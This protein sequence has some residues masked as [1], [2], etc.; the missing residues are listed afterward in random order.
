MLT[1]LETAQ[2]HINNRRYFLVHNGERVDI[3]TRRIKGFREYV[4]HIAKSTELKEGLGYFF[5]NEYNF[6]SFGLSE[7]V[8]LVFVDWDGKII[9]IEESFITNKISEKHEKT[10]YIYLFPAN[11]VKKNKML[12]NNTLTHEYQR[13]KD[14]L[15]I[16]DFL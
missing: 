4:R 9:H 6:A 14:E 11:T 13:R 3:I 15:K 1:L 16:S 7:P 5:Y 10:K 2:K 12:V 8:D